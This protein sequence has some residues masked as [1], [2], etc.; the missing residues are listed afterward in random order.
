MQ[1]QLKRFENDSESSRFIRI[2]PQITSKIIELI[3]KQCVLVNDDDFVDV[4]YTLMQN[5]P[6]VDRPGAG[7]N[8]VIASFTPVTILP[9]E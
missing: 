8:A 3:P 2:I 1:T 6:Y 7:G 4:Y 5:T 9:T